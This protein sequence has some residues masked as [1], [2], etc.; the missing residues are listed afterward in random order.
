MAEKVY[1]WV[2]FEVTTSG[3][4]DVRNIYKTQIAAVRAVEKLKLEAQRAGSYFADQAFYYEGWEV[5]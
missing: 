5:R 2:V 4:K 1:V 3:E